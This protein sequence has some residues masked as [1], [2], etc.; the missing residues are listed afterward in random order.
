[1]N[2]VLEVLEGHYIQG[3]GDS[4]KPDVEINLLPGAI[5]EANQFLHTRQDSTARLQRVAALIDG[6]ETP[7]GM[8][9]LSSVHWIACHGTSPAR[10]AEEAVQAI[11]QWNERKRKMFKSDHVCIAWTRLNE[12]KWL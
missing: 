4:Q 12:Q 6:F 9:L 11:Q 10:N 2:K 3:Y 8:E 7:Y 5:E 1:L